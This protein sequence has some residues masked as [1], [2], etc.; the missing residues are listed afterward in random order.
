MNTPFLPLLVTLLLLP[1]YPKAVD[2]HVNDFAE[3]LDEASAARVKEVARAVRSETGVPIVLVTVGSLAD[4][5][6]ESWS[7]ERYATNLYNEWGIGSNEANKGILLFVAVKDRKLRLTTGQGFG[8][9]FDASA[10]SILDSAILP[11]FKKGDFAGGIVAGVES[12]ATALRAGPAAGPSNGGEGEG[13][14]PRGTPVGSPVRGGKGSPIGWVVLAGLGVLALL[15][16]RS[17]FRG[18]FSGGWGGMGTPRPGFG[19]WGGLLMGGLGGFL[20]SALYDSVRRKG[21]S[22]HSFGGSSSGGGSWGGG[23]S[24]FGGGFSSGGGASGSW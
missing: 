24:S 17:V 9:S 21:S 15:A 11:R 13:W 6:A 10:R 2:D 14:T 5:K 22:G 7:V 1:D 16:L 20:G 23:T 12:I 3:V 19:G 4:Y 18:G 8:T